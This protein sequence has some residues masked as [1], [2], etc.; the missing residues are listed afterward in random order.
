M[1]LWLVLAAFALAAVTPFIGALPRD[2]GD[3][4]QALEDSSD[5]VAPD[6]RQDG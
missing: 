2:S 3:F 4:I 6:E 1:H 5:S